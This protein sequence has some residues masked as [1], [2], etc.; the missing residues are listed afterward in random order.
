MKKS[1]TLTKKKP[2]KCRCTQT[3][4]PLTLKDLP[5]E[6]KRRVGELAKRLALETSL[7]EKLQLKIDWLERDLHTLRR[8][9]DAV[10]QHNQQLAASLQQC[11]GILSSPRLPQSSHSLENLASTGPLT[12]HSPEKAVLLVSG[13]STPPARNLLTQ[14]TQGSSPHYSQAL[15]ELVEHVDAQSSLNSSSESVAEVLAQAVHLK[16]TLKY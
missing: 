14:S 1:K 3:E 7:R 2:V 13:L 9:H 4:Q 11:L 15:L 6:E 16:S 12:L 10:Q 5:L 8:T